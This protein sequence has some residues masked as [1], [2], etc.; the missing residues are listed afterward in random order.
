MDTRSDKQT[1]Y[2]IE[3]DVKKQTCQLRVKTYDLYLAK[4]LAQFCE[5]IHGLC[6]NSPTREEHA[7]NLGAASYWETIAP[8]LPYTPQGKD[9]MISVSVQSFLGNIVQI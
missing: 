8:I 4:I 2:F 3:K 1:L 9:T 5:R 6:H 7:D